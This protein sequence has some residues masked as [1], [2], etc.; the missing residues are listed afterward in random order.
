[1]KKNVY[2]AAAVATVLWSAVAFAGQKVSGRWDDG[3]I[4]TVEIISAKKAR[5]CHQGCYTAT[6]VEDGRWRKRWRRAA[7]NIKDIGGGRYR[8]TFSTLDKNNKEV[9]QV[10]IFN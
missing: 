7:I 4:A 9:R 3:S 8:V 5:Y 10:K 6:R 1:M 2:C